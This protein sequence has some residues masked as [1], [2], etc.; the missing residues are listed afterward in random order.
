MACLSRLDLA[1]EFEKL[2]EIG[3]TQEKSPFLPDSDQESCSFAS[4]SRKPSAAFTSVAALETPFLSTMFTVSGDEPPNS[5][6]EPRW[7]STR[8]ISLAGMR[9]KDPIVPPDWRSPSISTRIE[10][11]DMPRARAPPAPTSTP[12]SLPRTSP[13]VMTLKFSISLRPNTTFCVAASLRI[14]VSSLAPATSTDSILRVS[15]A[16]VREEKRINNSKYCL[17]KG[18]FFINSFVIKI[19]YTDQDFSLSLP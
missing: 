6:D 17:G 7:I 12:G 10:S 1:G 16:H 13:T 14:S 15:A 9:E 18:M 8:S 11:R 19:S 4:P 5:A 3:N 2:S